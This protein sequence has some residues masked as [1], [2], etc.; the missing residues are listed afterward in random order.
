MVSRS[1]KDD[2]KSDLSGMGA[3][4]LY[5]HLNCQLYLRILNKTPPLSDCLTYAVSFVVIFP[6]KKTHYFQNQYA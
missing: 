3:K 5:L 2:Q 4:T 1:Y 6:K